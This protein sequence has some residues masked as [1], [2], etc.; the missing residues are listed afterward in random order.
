MAFVRIS[1]LPLPAGSPG[2]MHAA[3]R[4]ARVAE[5]LGPAL[6]PHLLE[7]VPAPGGYEVVLA[8]SGWEPAR[9][10]IERCLSRVLGAAVA[11]RAR[12]VPPPVPAAGD[13]ASRD[14]SPVDSD[15]AAARLRRAAGRLA[16]RHAGDRVDAGGPGR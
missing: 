11:L 4:R 6:A 8:G 2:R 9:P 1:R 3:G 16:R 5:A 12:E 14:V 13:G 7:I 10:E 15:D